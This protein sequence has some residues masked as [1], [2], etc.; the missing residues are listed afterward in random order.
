MEQDEIGYVADI[1]NES[2]LIKDQTV[3]NSVNK[4]CDIK[5]YVYQHRRLDT[6]EIFYVG[7]GKEDGGKFLRSKVKRTSKRTEFWKNITNKTPYKIE[8]VCGD[9]T[10]EEACSKE[11]ELIALYGRRDLNLGTLVNMTDGGETTP[12][13]SV[14]TRLRISHSLKGNKLSEETK[15]KLRE[16]VT[17]TW[18]SPEYAEQREIQSIRSKYY[19]ELGILGMKGKPSPKKGKPFAGDKQKVSESLK[20]YW[21][22]QER[23]DLAALANGGKIFNVFVLKSSIPGKGLGGK[24][25]VTKGDLLFQSCNIS[26]CAE[27]LELER[28]HIGRCLKGELQQVKGYIFEYEN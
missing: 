28:R 3:I 8:I 10:K 1:L 9:L 22:N 23:R 19:Y 15:N 17:K 16:S 25:I 18:N 7:L 21:S 13:L 24:R 6:D 11:R 20:S 12:N 14:E 26:Y 5:Y 2:T 4:C 27:K